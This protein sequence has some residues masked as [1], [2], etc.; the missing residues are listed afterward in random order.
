[1]TGRDPIRIAACSL[2]R[3]GQARRVA[4]LRGLL[5]PGLRALRRTGAAAQLD[6]ALGPSGERALAA[7]LELE[8]EC[9]P[10][11]RFSLTR[12]APGLLRLDVRAAEPHEAAID[13]FLTLTRPAPRRRGPSPSRGAPR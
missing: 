1:V 8:A 2:D 6:L 3:D 11:W 5:A 12:R 4:E 10:F 13:A 7:L 9:C